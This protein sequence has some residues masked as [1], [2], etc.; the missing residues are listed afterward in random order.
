MY[1]TKPEDKVES[2]CSAK[3]VKVLATGYPIKP[4][5]FKMDFASKKGGQDLV[6]AVMEAILTFLTKSWLSLP[7]TIL[8]SWILTPIWQLVCPKTAQ[9]YNDKWEKRHSA[10]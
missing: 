7:L 3:K 10:H 9:K 1:G 5:P 2:R 4:P 6:Y 8:Q